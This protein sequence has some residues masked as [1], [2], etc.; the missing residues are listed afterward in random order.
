MKWSVRVKRSV[1]REIENLPGEDLR[2]HAL[3]K[4]GN[5]AENPFPT[6]SKKLKGTSGNLHRVR[7]GEYRILYSVAELSRTVEI[8]R[9]RHRKDVYRWL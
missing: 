9:V 7:V 3:T 1:E 6:G 5:L 2:V 4:I 8:I